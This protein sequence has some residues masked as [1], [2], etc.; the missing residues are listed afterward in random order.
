MLHFN[1]ISSILAS[2]YR[3]DRG[4]TE[5][6]INEATTG[7][8]FA[9]S[10]SRY[11]LWLAADRLLIAIGRAVRNSSEVPNGAALSVNGLYSFF[12]FFL[13]ILLNSCSPFFRAIH[14]VLPSFFSTEFQP[15]PHLTA[16]LRRWSFFLGRCHFFKM[17]TISID[18]PTNR[19]GLNLVLPSFTQ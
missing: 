3:F 8:F 5:S 16:P 9:G 15:P 12:L 7:F 14:S 4:F 10:T 13:R 19:L 1:V 11:D 2:R 17:A 18:T 6:A